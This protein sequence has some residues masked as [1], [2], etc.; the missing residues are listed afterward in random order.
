MAEE[1][2]EDK[3]PR[4]EAQA[5]GEG[6]PRANRHKR[7]RGARKDGPARENGAAGQVQLPGGKPLPA[8]KQV[9]TV[10]QDAKKD[11]PLCPLCDKP[12]YDMSNA[13]AE[14]SGGLPSHFDCILDRVGMAETIA[15][16]EKIVYLGGGAFGVVEFK[17]KNE[18][19]FV[20]KRRIQWEK[21]GEKKDWRK[22]MSSG[23]INL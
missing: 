21:E 22:T 9:D 11:S 20:V 19:S 1:R 3:A 2:R 4:P 15:P 7:F 14:P 17:D 18:N 5:P 16:N 13:I 23:I 10:T 12:I 8:Q 6:K